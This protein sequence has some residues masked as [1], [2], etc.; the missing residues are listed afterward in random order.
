MVGLGPWPGRSENGHAIA[1]Q[2]AFGGL[3]DLAQ[4]LSLPRNGHRPVPT[5]AV[6]VQGLQ[7]LQG[8]DHGR[9]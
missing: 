6:A 5:P 3:P 2:V 4:D 9:T 8:N 1:T 7:H